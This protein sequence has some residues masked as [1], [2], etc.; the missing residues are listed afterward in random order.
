MAKTS[1]D[2]N[3][4]HLETVDKEI[5]NFDHFQAEQI[6]SIKKI[7]D[8][9]NGF[10]IHLASGHDG[11]YPFI[12]AISA[13]NKVVVINLDAHLDTRQD[14]V[15]H[16][17]TPFRQLANE[18]GKKLQLIQVGIHDFANAPSNYQDVN[19]EVVT[20]SQL[21]EKTSNMTDN[22][23]FI[24]DLLG[25]LKREPNLRVVISIDIDAIDGSEM[26][27]VS[28]VNHDGIK[29][30]FIRELLRTYKKDFE[31]CYVGLYEYNPL[32]DD[33]GM[34]GARSICSLIHPFFYSN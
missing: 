4:F 19:M 28:A 2:R 26:K 12:K 22:K 9:T 32:F 6:N 5:T 27:A 33:L 11:I 13:N 1:I 16:S 15:A 30:E 29:T 3:I 20:M 34:S 25:P 18:L 31:D 17:G 10:F 7:T 23:K 8:N 14:K 24:N 21:K